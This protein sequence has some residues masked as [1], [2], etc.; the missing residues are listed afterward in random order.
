[1][2]VR[3]IAKW[4]GSQWHR[5]GNIN[6][7]RELE[8]YDNT[9]YALTIDTLYRWSD[10]QWKVS[11]FI[12]QNQL[13]LTTLHAFDNKLFVGGNF[14]RIDTTLVTDIAYLQNG[15]WHSLSKD[16]MNKYANVTTITDWRD[17]LYVGGG[18]DS[19]GSLKA[20]YIAKW[21]SVSDGVFSSVRSSS[22]ETRLVPNPFSTTATLYIKWQEPAIYPQQTFELTFYDIKGREVSFDYQVMA[23]TKRKLS[24]RIRKNKKTGENGIYFYK[25]T[26]GQNKIATGKFMIR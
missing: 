7:M 22:I 6:E 25:A 17:T 20:K 26:T 18:F 19:I 9:L 14:S 12:N 10:N 23:Q 11:M 4:D 16:T 5:A 13:R 15:V 1:M 21:Y 3:N 24:V 2:A 8:V